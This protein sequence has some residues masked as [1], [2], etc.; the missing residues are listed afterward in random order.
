LIERTRLTQ[1]LLELPFGLLKKEVESILI[2]E[3]IYDSETAKVYYDRL[4]NSYT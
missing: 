2:T 1:I 3:A 4:L